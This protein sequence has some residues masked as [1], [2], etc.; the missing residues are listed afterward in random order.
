MAPDSLLRKINP[1]VRYVNPSC[2]LEVKM[3]QKTLFAADYTDIREF[4]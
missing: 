3:L 2:Y 4:E 1:A